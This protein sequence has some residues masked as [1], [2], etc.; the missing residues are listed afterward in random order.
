MQEN[1]TE[2]SNVTSFISPS[3]VLDICGSAF[4]L[5]KQSAPAPSKPGITL[6]YSPENAWEMPGL[7]L[8]LLYMMHICDTVCRQAKGTYAHIVQYVYIQL[9]CTINTKNMV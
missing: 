2:Y 1:D 5:S 4:L 8:C 3:C 7:N 9:K 6:F